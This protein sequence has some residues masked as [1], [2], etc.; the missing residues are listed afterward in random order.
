MAPAM[1]TVLALTC[2]RRRRRPRPRPTMIMRDG[3]NGDYEIY[4][5][6]N[7]TILTAA[8]WA[9]RRG[10][11]RLLASVAFPAMPAIRR[12]AVARR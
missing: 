5:I 8:A 7:N 10:M 3:N 11:D 9:G 4:S 6:G 2:R 12:H 1:S